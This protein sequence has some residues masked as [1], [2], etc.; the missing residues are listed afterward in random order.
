MCLWFNGSSSPA[1]FMR[2]QLVPINEDFDVDLPAHFS[3]SPQWL[4]WS[5]KPREDRNLAKNLNLSADGVNNQNYC[6]TFFETTASTYWVDQSWWVN[7]GDASSWF[8]LVVVCCQLETSRPQ[9]HPAASNGLKPRR[10]SASASAGA[11]SHG[12]VLLG[13]VAA[14][15]VV[16]VSRGRWVQWSMAGGDCW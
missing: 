9:P 8:W 15:P 2:Q 14:G 4:W 5:L 3:D 11:M 12:R 10:W 13:V 6:E 1:S 7:G 16:S